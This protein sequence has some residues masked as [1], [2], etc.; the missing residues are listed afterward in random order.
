[1]EI[2]VKKAVG[3]IVFGAGL[4]VGVQMA[5]RGAGIDVFPKVKAASARKC[6]VVE[7]GPAVANNSFYLRSGL[8]AP[9]NSDGMDIVGF[10]REGGKS[11]ILTC[12]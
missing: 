9:F 12:E 6:Y 7:Y 10:S 3:F 2:E 1:M 8:P 11:F 5:L 4:A